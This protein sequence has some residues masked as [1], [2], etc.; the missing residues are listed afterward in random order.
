MQ[1]IILAAGCSSRLASVLDGKPKC[2]AQ[3]GGVHLIEYQLAVLKSFGITDVC[4][5]LGYQADQIRSVVGD[6][7]HYIINKQYAETNSLY[8]LWL[9]R[10]WVEGGFLLVNSDL[11]AHPQIYKRLLEASGNVLAYDSWTG[12]EGEQMKVSFKKRKLRKISKALAVEIAQGESIGMLK[13]TTKGAKS[14]FSE[15][16]VALEQGGKN[17]WAPA[18]V[19]RLADKLAIAGADIAGLPWIEIDFPQDWQNAREIVWP[20]IR[21]AITSAPLARM[22]ESPVPL[23]QLQCH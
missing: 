15:A 5:V 18:A 20:A 17:Q 6:R 11:L 9:A 23:Q 16:K 1:G 21:Q 2:L 12:T 4:L 10:K 14:L 13:F 8:S 3:V 19:N 22:V 7:C